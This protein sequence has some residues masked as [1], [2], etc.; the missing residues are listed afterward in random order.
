MTKNVV[1]EIA[2]KLCESVATSLEG[3]RLV[4]FTRTAIKEALVRILT[5]CR[6]IDISRDVHATKEQGKLL[7]NIEELTR[8]TM[9]KLTQDRLNIVAFVE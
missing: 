8:A 6:S 9:K 1:E 7:S 4:S 3:K 2:E 5:P